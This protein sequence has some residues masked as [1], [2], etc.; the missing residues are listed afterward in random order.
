MSAQK[1]E[2]KL[3]SKINLYLDDDVDS[4]I[5]IPVLKS[6]GFDVISPRSVNMRHKD[7]ENHLVFAVSQKAILLTRNYKD[8][9]IIHNEWISKK[10][11]HY[12]ICLVYQYNNSKKDLTPIKIARAINNLIKSGQKIENNIHVLNLWYY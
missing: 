4:D 11:S 8:F 6:N 9:R 2:D 10:A 12:G 7:D 3:A 1:K 5:L